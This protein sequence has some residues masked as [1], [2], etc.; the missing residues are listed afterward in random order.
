MLHPFNPAIV[1]VAPDTRTDSQLFNLFPKGRVGL[2]PT[3]AMAYQIWL[4][5]FALRYESVLNTAVGGKSRGERAV[6][7]ARKD[8]ARIAIGVVKELLHSVFSTLD[9]DSLSSVAEI[10]RAATSG[11]PLVPPLALWPDR[12]DTQEVE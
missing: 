11:I 2:H 3:V 8:H 5:T 4:S 1:P 10:M 12:P 7:A 6:L 9:G